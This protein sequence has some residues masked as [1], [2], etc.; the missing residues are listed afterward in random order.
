MRSTTGRAVPPARGAPVFL[1]REAE[2]AEL[3][4]AFPAGDAPTGRFIAI[5]GEG[6]IG[7]T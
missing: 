5:R 4:A 6:G 3:V 7:K 1:G 2:L